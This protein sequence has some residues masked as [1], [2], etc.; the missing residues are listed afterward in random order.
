MKQSN[1]STSGAQD[2]DTSF[3]DLQENVEEDVVAREAADDGDLD[4]LNSMVIVNDTSNVEKCPEVKPTVVNN[5]EDDKEKEADI[6]CHDNV[7][8]VLDDIE[9]QI[10]KLR[11][12][13]T[14]LSR[15][16]SSLMEVLES[17]HQGLPGT[18]LSDLEREEIGLEVTRLRG[19]AEDVRCELVTRY[20]VTIMMGRGLMTSLQEDRAAGGGQEGDG[21]GVGEAHQDSGG[22]P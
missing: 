18:D 7:R 5:D 14:K 2:S 22:G 20:A 13:V 4:E 3:E 8:Q 6:S 19:R 10:E 11:E 17:V 1:N 9:A 16:K 15:D 21:G 12:A